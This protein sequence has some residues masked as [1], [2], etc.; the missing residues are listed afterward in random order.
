MI[1][2]MVFVFLILLSQISLNAIEL[3][4][5]LHGT[6]WAHYQSA[7]SNTQNA[8]ELFSDILSNKNSIV[9]HEGYVNCLYKNQKYDDVIEY[10]N[11]NK[12]LI[13]ISN[14]IKK[15]Y[16]LSLLHVEKF[17][18]A[19][20]IL[21]ELTSRDTINLEL[22]FYAAQAYIRQNQL[23]NALLLID[24][25]LNNNRNEE[26]GLCILYFLQSQ[27]YIQFQQIDNAYDA[28]KKAV[29]IKPDF[30]K[31]W[32]LLAVFSEQHGNYSDAISGYKKYLALDLQ[33]AV[34]NGTC[35]AILAAIA[36]NTF[37]NNQHK[38]N[39]PFQSIIGFAQKYFNNKQYLEALSCAEKILYS[40][41]KNMNALCIKIESLFEMERFDEIFVL[42]LEKIQENPQE[43][44]WYQMLDWCLKYDSA[45]ECQKI[46]DRLK[47]VCI[48]FPN[49]LTPRLYFINFCIKKGN[50]PEAELQLSDI[51]TTFDN[52]SLSSQIDLLFSFATVYEQ[53]KKFD[54]MVTQWE[55]IVSLQKENENAFE[56]LTNYYIAIKNDLE[57][58][59][60]WVNRWRAVHPTSPL[61][62]I[63]HGIIVYK[64]GNYD[65]AEKLFTQA[66]INGSSDIGDILIYKAK[67]A[68]KKK[69]YSDSKDLCNQAKLIVSSD[70]L[71]VI[72][73][74]Q[75]KIAS[76]NP[77][78]QE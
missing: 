28:I 60:D 62:L 29:S 51:L 18:L 26:A 48:R 63:K 27:I 45:I 68:Y 19:D 8:V 38:K 4:K 58:A 50:Y 52:I 32:L 33:T 36:R 40:D 1:I 69:M 71:H 46:F 57:N 74:L 56:M 73:K 55:K 16:A 24:Q 44:L 22:C 47:D 11:Q 17:P 66:Q 75:D 21:I 43:K 7:L 72:Q 23:K 14:Q 10:I 2:R 54:C 20:K 53:Q 25:Y 78:Q 6:W 15:I 77:R 30:E 39:R 76:H 5:I 42:A 59:L 61:G 64:Q 31:G 49:E 12:Y 3:K 41:P 34:Q 70:K 35:Q 13:E 37:L 65:L 9:T 67:I